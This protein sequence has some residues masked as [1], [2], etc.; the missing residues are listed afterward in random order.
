LIESGPVPQDSRV[1]EIEIVSSKIFAI[2]LATLYFCG[3]TI[4]DG[5][6]ACCEITE[7][8]GV[9]LKDT[10]YPVVPS[11]SEKSRSLSPEIFFFG[12]QSR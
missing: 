11:D 8:L 3:A 9:K 2:W 4:A 7:L 12:Q 5:K 10:L 6:V 1:Y